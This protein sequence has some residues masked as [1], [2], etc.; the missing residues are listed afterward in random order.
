MRSKLLAVFAV[1]VFVFAFSAAGGA[2]MLTSDLVFLKGGYIPVYLAP[3]DEEGL[4]EVL[5]DGFAIQGEYNINLNNFWLGLSLEYQSVKSTIQTAAGDSD[6]F[7]NAF[8]VPMISAKLATMGGLYIGAGLS[9]KYL[10]TT[11]E[12]D[13]PLG[14]VEFDK[15]VDVWLNGILGY[16]MPIGEAVFLDLEGRFGINLTNKQFSTSD[17]FTDDLEMGTAYD[18]AFYVGIGTRARTS[19]Y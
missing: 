7:T 11:E 1:L 12:I 6:E 2:Q 14:L 8:L 15:E 10:L 19:N 3:F 9:A 5:S 18:L 13:T 16:Y 4:D 17:A